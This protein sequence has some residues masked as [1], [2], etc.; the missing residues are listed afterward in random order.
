M[1]SMRGRQPGRV[2]RLPDRPAEALSAFF[3]IRS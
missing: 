3:R 1:R 2:A